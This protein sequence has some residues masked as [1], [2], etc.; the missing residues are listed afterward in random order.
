[1]ADKELIKAT[2]RAFSALLESTVGETKNKS[3]SGQSE[4]SGPRYPK[5]VFL[6][7][8]FILSIFLILF[9]D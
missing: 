2:K 6:S 4:I 7:V 3:Q 8:I 1:M 5:S 9:L